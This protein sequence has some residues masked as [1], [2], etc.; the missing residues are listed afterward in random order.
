MLTP[1]TRPA[2]S[3]VAIV[4]A[5]DEYE[6]VPPV[7][8]VVTICTV[9]P[10]IT[11]SWFWTTRGGAVTHTVA[12]PVRLPLVAVITTDPGVTPVTTPA[13]LTVATLLALVQVIGPGGESTSRLMV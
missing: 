8:P 7:A 12:V 13:E 9:W 3:T 4:G 1:R 2:A 6:N 5:P 11:D 10:A